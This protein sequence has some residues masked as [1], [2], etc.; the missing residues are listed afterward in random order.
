MLN[1]DNTYTTGRHRH[2]RRSER[3]VAVTTIAR[4]HWSQSVD[5]RRPC[6]QANLYRHR[7][8]C[9]HGNGCE[10]PN[11]VVFFVA[12]WKIYASLSIV[13]SIIKNA[14]VGLKTKLPLEM[15]NTTAKLVVIWSNEIKTID[16]ICFIVE[17]GTKL[18]RCLTSFPFTLMS[19]II[20]I[21]RIFVNSFWRTIL[22]WA[23]LVVS[24]YII[25]TMMSLSGSK[26]LYHYHDDEP[27]W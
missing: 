13:N 18:C 7:H 19:A 5:H 21:Y 26:W 27:I 6:L 4:F 20:C 2:H 16:I 25:T 14:A 24:D 9:R 8:L 23:Y 12:S 3:G 11:N 15:T 17:L 22:W 10:V 1:V